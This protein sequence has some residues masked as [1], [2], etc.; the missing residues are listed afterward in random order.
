MALVGIFL[1]DLPLSLRFHLSCKIT[2]RIWLRL[3]CCCRNLYRCRKWKMQQDL[4]CLLKINNIHKI[5]GW[6][7]IVA[8]VRFISL[9]TFDVPCTAFRFE[10]LMCFAQLSDLSFYRFQD[11]VLGWAFWKLHILVC[12]VNWGIFKKLIA[13]TCVFAM[14]IKMAVLAPHNVPPCRKIVCWCYQ[15]KS[16]TCTW[17]LHHLLI[18]ST[19]PGRA[20][21]KKEQKKEIWNIVRSTLLPASG[22]GEVMWQL[23]C[24]EKR[25]PSRTRSSKDGLYQFKGSQIDPERLS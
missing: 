23:F 13:C 8:D 11:Q 1:V 10:L 18:V 6:D 3:C 19:V 25:T 12:L 2:C 4:S 24:E 22:V 15:I 21:D 16:A 5:P 7:Q 9:P 20:W 14:R 17:C